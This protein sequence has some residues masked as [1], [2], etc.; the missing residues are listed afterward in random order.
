MVFGTDDEYSALAL[1]ESCGAVVYI[2]IFH[3]SLR[4]CTYVFVAGPNKH[5][6]LLVSH[7]PKKREILTGLPRTW[8][9]ASEDGRLGQPGPSTILPKAY[10]TNARH[11]RFDRCPP[12]QEMVPW[13]ISNPIL[14]IDSKP[15]RDLVL[16]ANAIS[17][18]DFGIHLFACQ[19]YQTTGQ[20]SDISE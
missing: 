10:M 12:R 18:F 11:K 13:M 8:R 20:I 16:V 7:V 15:Y 19:S 3:V 14:D 9:P 6:V 4:V 17:L 1:A 2:H 5:N